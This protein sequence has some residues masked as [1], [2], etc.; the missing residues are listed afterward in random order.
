MGQTLE[1]NLVG[2]FFFCATQT[3]EEAIPHLRKQEPKRADAVK[4]DPGAS[5]EDHSEGVGAGDDGCSSTPHSI[6][7]PSCAPHICCCQIN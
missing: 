1:D 2:G 7:D 3:A 5:W 6:G 4:P